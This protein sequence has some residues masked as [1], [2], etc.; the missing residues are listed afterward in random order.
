MKWKTPPTPTVGDTKYDMRFA[1]FPTRTE[2]GYTV[3]LETYRVL[4]RYETQQVPTKFG[5]IEKTGWFVIR[6]EP[7][8]RTA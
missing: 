5:R 2:D 3:W 4:M 7:L 6:K 1:F 8:W